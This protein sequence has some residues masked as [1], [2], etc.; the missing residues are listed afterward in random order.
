MPLFGL[1]LGLAGA[2]VSL[3]DALNPDYSDFNAAAN[4]AKGM[5]RFMPI[6]FIPVGE[7]FE[8]TPMD[9]NH[10]NNVSRNAN[11]AGLSYL[12]NAAN[13]NIGAGMAGYLG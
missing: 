13:G 11:N 7:R 9:I 4:Y 8:Y 12:R 2:G 6:S 5:G 1:G 3:N 10:I